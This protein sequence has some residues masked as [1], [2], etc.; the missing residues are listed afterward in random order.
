M[1]TAEPDTPVAPIMRTREFIIADI[2]HRAVAER[3]GLAS[4]HWERDRTERRI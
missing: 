3:A 1:G 2:E 4:L